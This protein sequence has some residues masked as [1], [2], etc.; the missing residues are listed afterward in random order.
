VR[1][2]LIVDDSRVLRLHLG[3]MMQALGWTT[4][5][6]ENGRLALEALRADGEFVLALMDVN[7]PEMGGIE[8][9]KRVRVELPEHAVKVI[10]VTTEADSFL[11]ADVLDGGADEF[12]MKPF[13]PENLRAKLQLLSLA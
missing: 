5:E 1:K 9:V 7:M 12:L 13:T 4:A 8:C 2:V 3:R 10:M 6:A 11:I